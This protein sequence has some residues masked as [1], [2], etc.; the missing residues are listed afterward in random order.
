M[1][2]KLP[3][4]EQAVLDSLQG[5]GHCMKLGTLARDPKVCEHRGY[6]V[7]MADVIVAM[8]NRNLVAY[9]EDTRTVRG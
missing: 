7:E 6:G 2:R 1:E 5:N 3:K 8:A 4:V 9:D